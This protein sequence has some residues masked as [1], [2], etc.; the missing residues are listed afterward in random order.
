MS[1]LLYDVTTSDG[2]YRYTMEETG[3]VFLYRHGEPWPAGTANALGDKHLL[4]LVQD[5]ADTRERVPT[6]VKIAKYFNANNDQLENEF[7][8]ES[9][10]D[11]W[12]RTLAG[13]VHILRNACYKVVGYETRNVAY[14]GQDDDLFDWDIHRNLPDW[15]SE[16]DFDGRPRWD[17][18]PV[19]TLR[20]KV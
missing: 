12:E 1:N 18:R 5:L 9:E 13:L 14:H 19:Y 20:S 7:S 4:T 3:K 6:P 10:G 2:K 8:D 15:V 17:V 11:T 16:T